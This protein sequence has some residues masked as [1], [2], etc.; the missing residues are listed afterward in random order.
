MFVFKKKRGN[1]QPRTSDPFDDSTQLRNDEQLKSRFYCKNET[2]RESERAR[3][4]ASDQESDESNER[5]EREC[6]QRANDFIAFWREF[7][8]ATM[9]MA[10]GLRC[11]A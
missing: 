5:K 3:A 4:T 10:K 8:S 7:Q 6:L 11:G 2:T 9:A 1:R